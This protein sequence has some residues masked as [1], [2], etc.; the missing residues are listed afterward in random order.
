MYRTHQRPDGQPTRGKT[1]PNRLRGLDMFVLAM[2]P[3]V[4]RAP[5]ALFLDLGY[6]RVPRTTLESAARFR[7][8]NPELHVVGVEL[9]PARVA[10]ARAHE[11]ERTRFIRGGFEHDLGRSVHLMRAMNVLRQYPEDAVLPAW[12]KMGL[13][14]ADGGW[15]VEGTSCPWGRVVAVNL[16]QR[17]GDALHHEGLLLSLRLRGDLHPDLVPPVLPR[18]HLEQVV[19]GTRVHGL[20]EAWR[21]AWSASRG[22]AVFGPRQV[23]AASVADLDGVVRRRWLTRRGYL[24]WR[25]DPPERSPLPLG[26]A[27]PAHRRT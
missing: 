20:L 3:G 2:L 21:Q 5:G 27:T 17:R 4:L 24:W 14:L 25:P 7:A 18:S 22:L 19:P 12:R 15:L 8:L 9:D 16:L 6:G 26:G 10:A 13:R 23:F 11:D 1:A